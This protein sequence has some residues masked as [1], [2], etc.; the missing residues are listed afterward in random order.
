MT[1]STGADA[2][3]LQ[4]GK[5]KNKVLKLTGEVQVLNIKVWDIHSFFLQ[6]YIKKK[7][8]QI[9]QAKANGEDTS[10]LESDLQ[11]EQTKL[12]TDIQTDQGSAGQASKGIVDASLRLTKRNTT[13]TATETAA[14]FQNLP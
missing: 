2:D 3:A 14:N 7:Q 5:I 12:T 11:D 8:L 6:V 13:T 1:A 4:V 9:A 10:S